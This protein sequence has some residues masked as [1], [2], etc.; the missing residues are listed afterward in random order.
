MLKRLIILSLIFFIGCANSNIKQEKYMFIKG[1]NLYQKGNKKE[2]LDQYKKVYELDSKNILVIKEIAFLSYEL[3]D[4]NSS[5]RFYEEAYKLDSNDRDTVKNLINLYYS[6]GNYKNA[7][8]YLEKISINGDSDLLKLK[9][10]I[11][12][13]EGKYKEAYDILKDYQFNEE[14]E[15][16]IKIFTDIISKMKND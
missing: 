13:H 8:N 4:I 16:F 14:D 7:K 9:G 3:G 12:Y 2:A 15:N 10:Y 11:L 5:I 1:M 6:T